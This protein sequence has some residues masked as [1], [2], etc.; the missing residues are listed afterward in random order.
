MMDHLGALL[1]LNLLWCLYSIPLVTAGASTAAMERVVFDLLEEDRSGVAGKF[2]RYFKSMFWPS[3]VL[4]LF[5]LFAGAD[6]VILSSI[7]GIT[8]IE[9][10][11]NSPTKST[12]AVVILMVYWFVISWSFPLMAYRTG[13]KLGKTIGEGFALAVSFPGK[14]FLSMGIAVCMVLLSI[15]CPLVLLGTAS[16]TAYL[17]CRIMLPMIRRAL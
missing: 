9:I 2:R 11:L 7:A 1:L 4:W 14:T 3:T 17:C 13:G 5:F 16:C 8:K 15:L 10:L 6:L 12:A